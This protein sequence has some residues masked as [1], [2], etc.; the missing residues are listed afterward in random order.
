MPSVRLT[1][2][3]PLALGVAACLPDTRAPLGPRLPDVC[4]DDA[5]L[6][7]ATGLIGALDTS[8]AA[9]L[10]AFAFGQG[11]A[12]GDDGVLYGALLTGL[13]AAAYYTYRTIRSGHDVVA[14]QHA[15]N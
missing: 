6:V 5:N 3:L 11:G 2:L 9:G 14:C 4:T 1:L 7:V 15:R 12:F 10:G 8:V 13:P